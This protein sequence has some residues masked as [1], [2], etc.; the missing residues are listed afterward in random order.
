M[1]GVRP[2][3][4]TIPMEI[5]TPVAIERSGRGVNFEMVARPAGKNVRERMARVEKL[6]NQ[7]PQ[8]TKRGRSFTI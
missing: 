3:P 1:K 5:M 7:R 6:R 4:K 2:T 8:K